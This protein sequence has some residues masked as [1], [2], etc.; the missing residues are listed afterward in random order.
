M[1]AEQRCGDYLSAIA[2]STEGLPA[3]TTAV[4]SFIEMRPDL[5]DVLQDRARREGVAS[6]GRRLG[7]V[8]ATM[9]G[10]VAMLGGIGAGLVWLAQHLRPV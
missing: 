9:A 6:L 8:I 10:F 4:S 1:I 2:K 7:L 5:H 3:L